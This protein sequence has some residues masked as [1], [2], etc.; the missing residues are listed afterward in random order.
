M[1]IEIY[2]NA[3]EAKARYEI[4]QLMK[5]GGEKKVWRGQI[6]WILGKEDGVLK[7]L[8]LDYQHQ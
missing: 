3:V 8:S 5:I 1:K 7:I 2:Q 6:R 4:E